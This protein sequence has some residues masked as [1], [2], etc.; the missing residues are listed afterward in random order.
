MFLNICSLM[1]TKKSVKALTA[2][3]ADL[4]AAG[5]ISVLF[6][7][8]ILKSKFQTAYFETQIGPK[9]N[10]GSGKTWTRTRTRI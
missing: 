8:H 5:I 1:K 7:K 9:E 6:P 2:L 3:E 10:P 4:H